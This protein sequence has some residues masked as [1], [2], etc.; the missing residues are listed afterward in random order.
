MGDL[1]AAARHY[2]AAAGL[3]PA[4]HAARLNLGNTLGDLFRQASRL[5]HSHLVN[6]PGLHLTHLICA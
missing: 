5:A 1:E 6:T 3:D 2:R 4:S